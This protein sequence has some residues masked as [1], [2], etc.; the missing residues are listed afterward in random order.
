MKFPYS[1]FS[2]LFLLLVI[3]TI[4]AADPATV[5]LL[6][7]GRMNEAI[8]ALTNRSDP[9]SFNLRSRAYYAM[10]R[11]DD[12]VKWGERAITLRP[13]D[14]EYHLWLAREYGRKAGDSNPLTAA[15]VARKAKI[16]FERAVEL[17]PANVQARTDLS[18]YY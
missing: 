16:E 2:I 18:Q 3:T 17:D 9:E 8:S 10:E 5:Q 12:A 1:K 13:Q 6:S 14:A 15:G 11:W 7:L 4:G